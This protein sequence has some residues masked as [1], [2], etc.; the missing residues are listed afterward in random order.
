[1]QKTIPTSWCTSKYMHRT[2]EQLIIDFDDAFKG[3]LLPPAVEGIGK[4]CHE[5]NNNLHD[6]DGGK[7]IYIITTEACSE[8]E[9]L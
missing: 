1:M 5:N 9:G 2:V 3:E 6:D 7:R 8:E 4:E